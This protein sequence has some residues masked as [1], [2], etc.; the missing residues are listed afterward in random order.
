MKKQPRNLF[1]GNPLQVI[2]VAE[3]PLPLNPD[4]K[5]LSLD[6]FNKRISRY[7]GTTYEY[8]ESIFT[9]D[10]SFK[11]TE[12][13]ST[14]EFPVLNDL[15]VCWINESVG[16]GVYTLRDVRKGEEICV[17]TGELC[18]VPKGDGS[19]TLGG[20]EK[21]NKGKRICTVD[22]K[23]CAGIAGFIQSAL[24]KWEY[25][26]IEEYPLQ[27]RNIKAEEREV[28]G[29]T[30]TVLVADDDIP[31]RSQ[32]LVNYGLPYWDALRQNGIIE[33]SFSAADHCQTPPTDLF[34][35]SDDVTIPMMIYILNRKTLSPQYQTR[36][37]DYLVRFHH[38]LLRL[39]P[40]QTQQ[41]LVAFITLLKDKNKSFVNIIGL[42]AEKKSLEYKSMLECYER[43][44]SALSCVAEFIPD[45]TAKPLISSLE[46]TDNG[47][48]QCPVEDHKRFV[49]LQL[50]AADAAKKANFQEAF[51]LF[52]EALNG[53]SNVYK[54]RCPCLHFGRTDIVIHKTIF[55]IH[56]QMMQLFSQI[57]PEKAFHH[58]FICYNM[59]Q[60]PDISSSLPKE[61]MIEI[62]SLFAKLVQSFFGQT[63]QLDASFNM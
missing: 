28:D 55:N 22:A 17:Y 53:F 45:N 38:S 25:Y 16:Y 4:I 63:P 35:F 13:K 20:F 7:R 42:F 44:L 59:M 39:L 34:V 56:V 54:Q 49:R 36:L 60:H 58:G 27:M 15:V 48:I 11:F 3:K 50:Q 14:V 9:N 31:A 1:L 8:S 37:L 24:D 51:K 18:R 30:Y 12:P 47:D 57:M 2:K 33:R 52:E 29:I 41:Q 21:T 26:N 5:E 23:S 46:K 61:K 19:Y 32:L 10:D 6:D 62:T 43:G 40:A